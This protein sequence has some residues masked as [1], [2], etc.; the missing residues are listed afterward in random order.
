VINSYFPGDQVVYIP[1]H[2]QGNEHHKD[3]ERGIVT[4]V[5][6]DNVFVLFVGRVCPQACSSWSLKLMH[7]K[8]EG[9][10]QQ[11]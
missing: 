3:C 11:R 4:S 9:D 10:G 7:R 1:G 6:G 8:G 2:A 5:K